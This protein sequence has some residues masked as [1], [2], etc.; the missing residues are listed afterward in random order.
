M[1]AL[2]RLFQGAEV[3]RVRPQPEPEPPPPPLPP[4]PPPPP[5]PWGMEARR[6]PVH[7]FGGGERLARGA[8]SGSQVTVPILLPLGSPFPA[9]VCGASRP[10]LFL[11]RRGVLLPR[12][13]EREPPWPWGPRN[14]LGLLAPAREGA[15]VAA[16]SR[17]RE[18]NLESPKVESREGV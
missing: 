4:P 17:A 5:P 11:L 8:P 12:G 16:K 14:F 18:G 3:E 9:G 2:R 13:G 1:A 15:F 10:A 6:C 7:G